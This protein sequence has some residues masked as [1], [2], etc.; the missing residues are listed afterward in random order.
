[1]IF[2]QSLKTLNFRGSMTSA[3]SSTT[4][5]SLTVATA[6]A[7]FIPKPD[8]YSVTDL[9]L[10]SFKEKA[11][12]V[13]KVGSCL[14]F[15]VAEAVPGLP[16]NVTKFNTTLRDFK[17]FISVTEIPEKLYKLSGSLNIL[18]ADLTGKFNGAAEATWMKVGNSARKAFS[19]TAGLINNT[20]D[21]IDFTNLFIPISKETLRWVSGINFAATLGFAGN[22]AVEQIENIN[23]QETISPKRTT[24][25]L[26]NL[27]RD[28]SYVA[29]GVIGLTFILTSTPIVP[30]MIVACSTSGLLFSISSYFYEKMVDPENK[31]KNLNPAIVVENLVNQRVHT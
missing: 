3:V 7:A 21:A 15:W 13:A 25:Y 17:N 28:V 2:N 27:A 24:L 16:S 14:I 26:I 10:G 11:K 30:W 12:D 23:R 1:M 5:V 8:N 19:D 22:D 31:G 20:A 6:N 18:T 29:L 4:P 9:V